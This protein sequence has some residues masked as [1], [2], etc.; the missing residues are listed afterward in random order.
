[1]GGGMG[2]ALLCTPYLMSWIGWHGVWLFFAGLSAM[3]AFVI[4]V[5][6]PQLSQ[7]R[8]VVDIPNLISMTLKHPPAWMLALMFGTYAGQWFGLVGFLPT[9]YQ[10]NNIPI[11]MA[12]V[13]T[14]IVAMS[15]AVGTAWCGMLLQRGIQAKLLMQLAYI[16]LIVCAVSFY[17]FKQILPFSV[18]YTLVLSFSLFGG[19]I[20]AIIFSQAMH[21]A[22]KPIAISTTIGLVLQFSAISQ[23][24]LPPTIALTVS[25]SDG[26][27]FWVG[28]LMAILSCIGIALSQKLFGQR[29]N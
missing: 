13:F 21:F 29:Y 12:G 18:Q 26:S 14:A 5:K 15:N 28:I 10:Q 17:C 1:M 19:Y 11:Q 2:I 22:V 4:Y 23:F 6:V 16:V 25:V 9:I 20:A 7:N 8:L 27:W 24:V 3:I